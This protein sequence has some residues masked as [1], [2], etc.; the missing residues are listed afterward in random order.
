MRLVT[1][2]S[3]RGDRAGILV[4]DSVV[5]AWDALGGEGST[6][7]ELLE[8]DR[9]GDLADAR[10]QGAPLDSVQ[11]RPPVPDPQKIVCVGLNYRAH[12]AA[13][14]IDPPES[15]TFFAKFRNALAAP[16]A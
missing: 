9:L 10:G 4:E 1:Y 8:G 5:D 6:V 3:G 7:R 12:A 11:L 16:D 2:R 15:P 14:G 13:A